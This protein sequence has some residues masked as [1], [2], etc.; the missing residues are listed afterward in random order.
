[1]KE[2]KL[3]VEVLELISLAALRALR[4]VE[5]RSLFL[6]AAA[7]AIYCSCNP[8]AQNV[9]SQAPP[10]ISGAVQYWPG[11]YWLGIAGEKGWFKEAGLNDRL[12]TS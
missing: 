10:P 9:A 11:F 6:F 7:L 8:A 12:M 4:P 3:S 2:K 5:G 1:M